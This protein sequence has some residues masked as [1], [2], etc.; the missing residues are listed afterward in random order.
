MCGMHGFNFGLHQHAC[1]I[2]LMAKLDAMYNDM[3]SIVDDL[4]NLSTEGIVDG[5]E[6]CLSSVCTVCP[7]KVYNF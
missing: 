4:T 1:H 7:H 3:D 6:E 2:R 5:W